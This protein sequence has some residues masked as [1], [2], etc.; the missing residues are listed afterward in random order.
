M[1]KNKDSRKMTKSTFFKNVLIKGLLIGT[2]TGIS[3]L[4]VLNLLK[5]NFDLK[6]K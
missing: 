6:F 1:N 3:H 2:I 4:V 5:N